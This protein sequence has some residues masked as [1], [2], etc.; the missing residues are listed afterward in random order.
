MQKTVFIL[1][2]TTLICGVG[3]ILISLPVE[4]EVTGIQFVLDDGTAGEIKITAPRYL[5]LGDEGNLSLGIMLTSPEIGD[6]GESVKI[7]SSLVSLTL[8]MEPSSAVTAIIP[9]DGTGKFHWTITGH[10]K[11]EQRATL[12]CFRQGTAGP[13]LILARDLSFE[14]KTILGVGFRLFRWILV[15]IIILCILLTGVTIYRKRK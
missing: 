2:L 7:K 8:Q 12:W 4:E 10:N 15:E 9:T 1:L 11:E 3:L 5:R 6:S 13:E 14:V